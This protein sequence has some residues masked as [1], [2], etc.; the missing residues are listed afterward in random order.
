[1]QMHKICYANTFNKCYGLLGSYSQLTY[2]GYALILLVFLR[3]LI[4]SISFKTVKK[5]VNIKLKFRCGLNSCLITKKQN[6]FGE[7]CIPCS[8]AQYCVT[9]YLSKNFNKLSVR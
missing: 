8:H 5:L 4:K 6:N 1:M 2:I 3:G 9:V 7:P